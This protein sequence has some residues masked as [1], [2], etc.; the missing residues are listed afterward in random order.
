LHVAA[1]LS[2]HRSTVLAELRSDLGALADRVKGSGRRGSIEPLLAIPPQTLTRRLVE[3]QL[4]NPEMQ[5]G[6]R[7]L[8]APPSLQ[9][10]PLLNA[11]QA[12][13]IV[14]ILS[15]CAELVVLDLSF[16]AREA[17][18]TAAPLADEVVIVLER[19]PYAMRAAQR[20]TEELVS[21]GVSRD[22]L[23]CVVVTRSPI[24]APIPLDKLEAD[25]GM[26]LLAVMPPDADLCA[27]AESL[28]RLSIALQPDGLTA[29]TYYDLAE[30]L[31]K[32]V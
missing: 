1:V 26:P 2:N 29:S 28:R 7:V 10:R 14:T 5:P 25:L 13:A 21:W 3:R 30:E 15:E 31:K 23:G 9:N 19:T 32:R 18:R 17:A 27:V 6:L 4:W 12:Q 22:A 16:E 24:G 20:A 11:E 8:S